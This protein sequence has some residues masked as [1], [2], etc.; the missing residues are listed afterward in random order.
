MDSGR[1]SWTRCGRWR[2]EL[3]LGN[4]VRSLAQVVCP[5]YMHRRCMGKTELLQA[6]IAGRD[7]LESEEVFGLHAWEE[8]SRLSPR[9]PPQRIVVV[10]N[11]PV[12]G[13]YGGLVD[14]ADLVNRCNAYQ[15]VGA[16]HTAE[17]CAKIGSKCVAQFICLHAG[18]YRIHLCHL[19]H[20]QPWR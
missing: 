6:I 18:E 16:L 14:G 1:M 20:V 3:W 7:G 10:G 5:W 4:S 8:F 13:H 12:K 9:S 19:R 17:G 2:S 11:G 15:R